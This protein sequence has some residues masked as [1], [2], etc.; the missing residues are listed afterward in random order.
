MTMPKTQSEATQRIPLMDT[1]L[2]LAAGSAMTMVSISFL[3]WLGA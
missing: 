3:A 2:Y 1:L